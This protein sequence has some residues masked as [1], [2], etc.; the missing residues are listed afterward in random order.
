MVSHFTKLGEHVWWQHQY[1]HTVVCIF[2]V[3]VDQA[4]LIYSTCIQAISQ[5][6]C[7]FMSS[8]PHPMVTVLLLLFVLTFGRNLV[9]RRL[10]GVKVSSASKVPKNVPKALGIFGRLKPFSTG[11]RSGFLNKLLISV[12]F[13]SPHSSSKKDFDLLETP[14]NMN[15]SASKYHW[16]TATIHHFGRFN[17]VKNLSAKKTCFGRCKHILLDPLLFCLRHFLPACLMTSWSLVCKFA[18]VPILTLFERN[19]LLINSQSMAMEKK[20]SLRKVNEKK[21]LFSLHPKN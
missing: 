21:T 13:H 17:L 4:E 19:Q 5:N 12:S 14:Q 7:P 10:P 3:L 18:K 2:G 16:K 6:G 15:G 9:F 11:T 20:H 8:N 1:Q